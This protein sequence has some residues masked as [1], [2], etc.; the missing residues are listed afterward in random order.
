MT[1]NHTELL[2]RISRIINDVYRKRIVYPWVGGVERAIKFDTLF[3]EKLQSWPQ[4]NQTD[5]V[6]GSATAISFLLHKGQNFGVPTR[7]GLEA[8]INRL[9]G[10]CYQALV[11]I[12]HLGPFARIRFTRETYNRSIRELGYSEQDLPYREED[13]HFYELL[14][15]VLADEGIDILEKNV[16]DMPVPNLRLDVTGIGDV[17]IYHCLFDEE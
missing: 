3:R 10:E 7:D 11:E 6:H 14:S 8:R 16:L 9:G 17:T 13:S 12:S 15:S 2:E 1:R 5:Y 4:R